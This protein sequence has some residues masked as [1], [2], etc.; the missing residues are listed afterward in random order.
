MQPGTRHASGRR[1]GGCADNG[2]EHPGQLEV[3]PEGEDKPT[4]APG[5]WRGSPAG[6]TLWARLQPATRFPTPLSQHGTFSCCSTASQ[7]CGCLLLSSQPR[8]LL[9]MSC[10]PEVLWSCSCS[11]PLC[12]PSPRTSSQVPRTSHHLSGLQFPHPRVEN[13]EP[14]GKSC[15]SGSFLS[16]QVGR[17]P[18]TS[19]STKRSGTQGELVCWSTEGSGEAAERGTLFLSHK[20]QLALG[21]Q[22][23]ANLQPHTGGQHP[24]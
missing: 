6:P 15:P 23:P 1:A 11:G 10:Y 14:C 3:L 22:Q 2:E 17:G 13:F 21:P 4:V 20:W 7:T 8:V 5:C 16:R 12:T 24:A 19:H 9:G 18:R